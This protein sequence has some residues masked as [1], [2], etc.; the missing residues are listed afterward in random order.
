M[1]QFHKERILQRGNELSPGPGQGPCLMAGFSV[2]RY[3]EEAKVR[4][5]WANF[6]MVEVLTVRFSELYRFTRDW[7]PEGVDFGRWA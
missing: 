2:R 6:K 4:E 3:K 1:R 7:V 5:K